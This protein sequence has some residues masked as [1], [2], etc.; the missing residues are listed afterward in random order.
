MRVLHLSNTKTGKIL[1]KETAMERRPPI[2][3]LSVLVLALM[4]TL[5][6]AARH[7][8]SFNHLA[9][10]EELDANNGQRISP[11]EMKDQAQTHYNEK[12]VNNDGLLSLEEITTM[13]RGQISG[14]KKLDQANMIEQLDGNIDGMPGTTKTAGGVITVCRPKKSSRCIWHRQLRWLIC[15]PICRPI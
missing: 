13:Q 7:G 3:T 2:L 11:Q 4:A 15:K 9:S 1:N 8:E 5:G 14:M 6:T 12:G 10:F